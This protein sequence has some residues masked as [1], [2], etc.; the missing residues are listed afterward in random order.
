VVFITG[1]DDWKKMVMRYG[2]EFF[3]R[4]EGR[5]RRKRLWGILRIGTG[6]V[7]ADF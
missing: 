3:Y 4:R 2:L 6:D 7:K 5:E 1:W